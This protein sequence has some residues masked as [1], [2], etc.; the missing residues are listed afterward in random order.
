[1]KVLLSEER[2]RG[3]ISECVKMVLSEVHQSQLYHFVSPRQLE[4][5]LKNGFVLNGSEK[6]WSTSPK[7]KYFLSLTRNKNAKQ[8]F[9]YMN[10]GYGGGGGTYHN[11]CD[12]NIICRIEINTDLL[13]RY[14]KVMPFDYFYHMT[15]DDD[16][17]DEQISSKEELLT[18]V[19]DEEELYRQ[20]FSQAEER[21]YSSFKK[22]GKI[23]SMKL[24]NK[25][26]IFINPNIK[27][28]P[29]AFVENVMKCCKRYGIQFNVDDNLYSDINRFSI[30]KNT[31]SVRNG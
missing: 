31:K 3:L 4:F 6:K 22:F 19:D 30:G 27:E 13:G 28:F 8:G 20:P 12:E 11:D 16:D 1:M 26:D 18:Y 29:S 2:L 10:Y 23:N 15:G 25:I 9:P 5:I 7:L 17:Y 21:L 14:G 24:I